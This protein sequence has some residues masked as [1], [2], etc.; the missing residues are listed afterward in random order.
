L[1]DAVDEAF[2]DDG[3]DAVAGASRAGNDP[4]CISAGT[5]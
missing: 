5:R 3:A 4:P 1:T 2:P